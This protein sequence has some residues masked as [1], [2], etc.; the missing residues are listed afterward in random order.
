MR[1]QDVGHIAFRVASIAGMSGGAAA[2]GSILKLF[3]IGK[4]RTVKPVLCLSLLGAAVALFQFQQVKADDGE[5]DAGSFL[6]LSSPPRFL[7]TAMGILMEW[8]S[9]HKD[10]HKEGHLN[11]AIS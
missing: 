11:Q 3:P 6:P 2:D 9:C 5:R 7:R 4:P 8:L 1:Y 10:F